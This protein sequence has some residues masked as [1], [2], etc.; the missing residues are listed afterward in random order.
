MTNDNQKRIDQDTSQG[1]RTTGSK[2]LDGIFL[3][4]AISTLILGV[5]YDEFLL[6]A[7][8]GAFFCFLPFVL[9]KSR[10]N[11]VKEAWDQANNQQQQPQKTSESDFRICSSCGWKNPP[12][13]NFCHDCGTKLKATE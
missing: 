7:F 5:V 6:G 4:L 12:S 8:I 10:R 3:I 1:E 2:L 13:N 11:E 9:T